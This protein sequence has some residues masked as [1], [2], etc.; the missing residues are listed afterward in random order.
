MISWAQLLDNPK[1]QLP[2]KHRRYGAN[3]TGR[4]LRGYHLQLWRI[5]VIFSLCLTSISHWLPVRTSFYA[6]ALSPS[7]TLEGMGYLQIV[8]QYAQYMYIHVWQSLSTC[9]FDL[10]SFCVL[11][12]CDNQPTL[13]NLLSGGLHPIKHPTAR[14]VPFGPVGPLL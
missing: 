1:W 5:S 2:Y 13:S 10:G 11:E 14:S 8:T 9:G 12:R 3:G 7:L 4:K 6:C